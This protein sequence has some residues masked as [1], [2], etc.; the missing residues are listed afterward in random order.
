MKNYFIDVFNNIKSMDWS[1]ET[2]KLSKGKLI[3]QRN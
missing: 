1:M 2:I 3:V